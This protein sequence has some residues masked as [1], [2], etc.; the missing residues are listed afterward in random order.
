MSTEKPLGITALLAVLQLADGLFPA[1]GFA[2]SLTTH[3]E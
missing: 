3:S 2:H 1:G